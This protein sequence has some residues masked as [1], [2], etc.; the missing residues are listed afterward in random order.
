MTLSERIATYPR[1][2]KVAEAADILGVHRNKLYAMIN[3]HTI[4]FVHVGGLK[5]FDPASLSAWVQKSS[6]VPR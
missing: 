1:A 2:L 3:A 6:F 4:P 5:R